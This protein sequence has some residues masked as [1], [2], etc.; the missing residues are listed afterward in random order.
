[1]ADEIIEEA[2]VLEMVHK[3]RK[4]AKTKRWGARKLHY[5]LKEEMAG[6]SIKLGRDKFFDLLRENGMLVKPRKRNF[7]TT[8][9]HHWLWKYENLIENIVITQPNQLWVA[10]I[11][12]LKIDDQ[13]YYLYLLTD[14]YSQKIVGFHIAMD[15]K[16]ISAVNALKRALKDNPVKRPDSLI[17]H[18]DRGIQYCSKEYTTI[19]KRHK[20]MISMTK[21]ASPQENAIAERVNGIL[22]EEWLYDLALGRDETPYKKIKEAITIYNQLRPHNSLN[23]MT[24]QQVHDQGFLRHKA[25]RVIGK[26][27]HWIKKTDL[28]GDQP[29][30]SSYAIGPNDYALSSCSS[31]ELDSPSSWHCKIGLI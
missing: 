16:A 1:M 29:E 18:S 31:A 17:H 23:N 11:T 20:V 6:I 22:K 12:Y 30:K 15:L 24:P 28:T 26:T 8:Q 21:P 3:I 5:L 2:I 7:F 19:L 10:D 14:T 9:S 27:Y 4:R 25:E 13:V